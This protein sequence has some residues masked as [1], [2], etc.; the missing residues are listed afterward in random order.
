MERIE[1]ESI[2][3]R[4]VFFLENLGFSRPSEARKI[5][6]EESLHFE[7]IHA[8]IYTSMGYDLIIIAPESLWERVHVVCP[9]T[10][11]FSDS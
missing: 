10:F 4:Q 7:D 2:Y 1:R 9:I 6:F 8:E 5:T 11:R 3:Q